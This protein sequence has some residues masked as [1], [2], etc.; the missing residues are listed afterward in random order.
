MFVEIGAL[1]QKSIGKS[2]LESLKDL[3]G[4][5]LITVESGR[6]SDLFEERQFGAFGEAA[7]LT[8]IASS[9]NKDTIFDE[10]YNACGLNEHKQGLVFMTTEFVKSSHRQHRW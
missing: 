1:I 9:N 2:V 7:I 6:S 8:I 10:L 3:E 4:V 5:E